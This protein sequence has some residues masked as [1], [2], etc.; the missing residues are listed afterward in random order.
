M[1]EPGQGGFP[2]ACRLSAQAEKAQNENH[3]NDEADD[4][5]DVVHGLDLCGTRFVRA[6]LDGDCVNQG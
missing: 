4:I 1:K 2:R 6:A 3:D 5:D